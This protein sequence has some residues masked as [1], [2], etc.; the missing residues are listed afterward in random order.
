MTH[1]WPALADTSHHNSLWLMLTWIRAV[2]LCVCYGLL[3]RIHMNGVYCIWNRNIKRSSIIS[4]TCTVLKRQDF[5]RGRYL[6][7]CCFIMFFLKSHCSVKQKAQ[8]WF[9]V[10]VYVTKWEG[11][12]LVVCC[13]RFQFSIVLTERN[14]T[15]QDHTLTSLDFLRVLE[16]KSWVRL[17]NVRYDKFTL[18]F[19]DS[20]LSIDMNSLLMYFNTVLINKC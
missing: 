7:L 19:F 20:C 13:E 3:T 4:S 6:I 2:F 8:N 12:N 1:P 16:V 18:L 9:Y 14:S 17:Q 5:L 11:W 10:S 15:S